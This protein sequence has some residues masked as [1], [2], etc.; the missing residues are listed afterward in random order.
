MRDVDAFV[1][2]A[3]IELVAVDAQQGRIARRAFSRFGKGRHQAGLNF[4]D[5]VAYALAIARGEP[6][7]FKGADLARTDVTPFRP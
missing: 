7:L 1:E 5:R 3:D 4:G 6:L 2:R